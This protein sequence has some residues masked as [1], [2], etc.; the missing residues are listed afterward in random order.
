MRDTAQEFHQQWLGMVQPSEGLVVSIP[1]LEEAQCLER[2]PLAI[3][4][5]LRAHCRPLASPSTSDPAATES[6]R[7][8][9]DGLLLDAE[10]LAFEAADFDRDDALPEA[11]S[12]WVPEGRERLAPTLA[13]RCK[14]PR[15]LS[16]QASASERAGAGYELLIQRLPDGL[17]FDRPDAGGSWRYPPT[18]KLDRLL[19]HCQV[20][21]GLLCNGQALRLIYAPHGES[22]GW[23]TFK[24]ADMATTGGRPILDALLML[25]GRP[26]FRTRPPEA[27]LPALLAASRRRQAN[28]TEALAAQVFEALATLL[29]GFEAA[30]ERDGSDGLQDALRLDDEHLYGGLLTV[31]LRLVFL[32]Y[33]EDRSLVPVEHTVYQNHYSVLGLFEQLQRDAGEYPDSMDRRFGAWDRLLALFRMVWLGAEHGDFRM[34]PRGGDLFDPNTY[35]FL[36]GWPRGGSAPVKVVE[37]RAAVR[38]PSVDDHAIFQ[39]LRRLVIFEGQRLSYRSLDVEQIGSVYEALM[40]YRVERVYSSAVCVRPSRFWVESAALFEVPPPR[41]AAW[42][43]EQAGL[44]RAAANKLAKA[45]SKA[46]DPAELL[47]G[48][49]AFAL[50]GTTPAP[51]GRLV[52]QPG[53]E[54][55]RTSSHYTPRSLS[56]PIVARTLEPLVAA[57]GEEPSAEHLLQ[58]KI[59]DPAMG[60]GA[61]LVETCRWLAERVV[62]A[63]TREGRVE[64]IAAAHGDVFNHARRLVAQRCLYGVDKNRFAVD[65]AKLSLWLETLARDLPFTFLD[66]AL[67][68]GDSLVGLDFE[69]LRGFHWQPEG[70]QTL[71]SQAL[72]QALDEAISLRQQILD[73]AGEGESA[74]HEKV[75]L[76]RD[77][78]DALAHAR[79][80]GDLVVGAFFAHGKKKDRLRELGERLVQVDEWLRGDTGRPPEELRQMQAQIRQRLPVFHWMLEFPEV[81]YADRPD[82]LDGD[83]VN[84]AAF[85]DGFVGNPPFL[86]GKMISTNHGAE[87]S[88]WLDM[89]HQAGKNG[90]LVAHFFL[91]AN[92]LLGAHGTIGLIATN[93][94]A[95]G[96]TRASGLQPLVA[97][98]GLRIY[99]A[100]RTQPWP[101]SAAVIVSVVHLAKGSPA[102]TLGPSRLDGI[103]VKAINS[104]LRPKVER[105]DPRKLWQNRD[106][107]FQGSIVLGMGFTLKPDERQEFIGRDP[108]NEDRIFPYLGGEEVNTRPRQTHRRYVISFGEMSL[109]E[110]ST[111]PDLLEILGERVKPERARKTKAMAAW[112]W[113]HHWRS[114]RELYSAIKSQRLCLVSSRHSKHLIFS[115]QPTDRVFSEALNVFALESS[116]AFAVLQS[117]PHEAW[118]RLLSSSMKTDLRYAA[119]DCFETFPFPKPDPRAEIPE[120]EDIGQR[121]YQARATYLVDT[122]QGLTQCY[123]RLKDPRE[124]DPRITELRQL[125]L[126][127]DRAVLA[128]YGWGEIDVPPFTTPETAAEHRALEAFKDDIIDRLFQLN[129]DRAAEEKRLGLAAEK[130]RGKKAVAKGRGKGHAGQ[131]GLF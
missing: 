19:R 10:L 59:C 124:A 113:W 68:W 102:Q 110:A 74:Q 94:V 93:T 24:V 46:A 40:G 22:S 34:P 57:L 18:A 9:L 49:R 65:L 27:R 67:R 48:L 116:A 97:R 26:S 6:L 51:A 33:A 50:K 35:P 98:E 91:R 45:L 85:I 121:L 101:G 111:W 41:R 83:R 58:L 70:Q 99:D 66:H 129:A 78:N 38:V 63:W 31:L 12:L 29:S 73:L 43:Q 77:A 118:A 11:L 104:R 55:R 100:T 127:M 82:P 87:F 52:L 117:R 125:H 79:L 42:L 123:N 80:I 13:L 61:F 76:L 7:I 17:D 37:K 115:T 86:G 62:A 2:R 75:R 15:E 39:L 47:A 81:F 92:T 103:D 96:D 114:R 32:L 108:R 95:Q 30:A 107:C 3:R 112:P 28:V 53:P 69:Q 14:Q 64:L 23:L 5:R 4:D 36:E 44:L 89:L 130:G 128:A 90:D 88:D 119:S 84:H 126:E 16:E 120:L 71:A 72:E 56:A 25:L 20:P 109:D 1:V 60:S 122:S 131:G 21:I 105:P 8:E 54:R 106:L